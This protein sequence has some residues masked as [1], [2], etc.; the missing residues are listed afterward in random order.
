MTE[1]SD[2]T[3]EEWNIFLQSPFQ[4]GFYIIFSAPNFWA[5]SVSL[6]LFDRAYWNNLS[7]DL[8]EN[9]LGKLV[10][11]IGEK[12]ENPGEIPGNISLLKGDPKTR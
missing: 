10:A 1:R 4:I 5:Y 3:F 11:D 12:S 8:P 6:E 7:R 9:S 2:F